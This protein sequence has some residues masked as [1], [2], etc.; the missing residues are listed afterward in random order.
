MTVANPS[1]RATTERNPVNGSGIA[2]EARPAS[3]VA[4]RLWGFRPTSTDSAT[5]GTGLSVR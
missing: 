4:V 2:T 1:L 3:S 5:P